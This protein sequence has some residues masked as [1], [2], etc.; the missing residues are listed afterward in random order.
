MLDRIDDTI[1]AV[2]SAPGHSAVALIRLSGPQAMTIADRMS[3]PADEIPLSDRP[4]SSR[5]VGE[6]AIEEGL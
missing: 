5:I 4:G 6:V 1:V 2:S 3:K